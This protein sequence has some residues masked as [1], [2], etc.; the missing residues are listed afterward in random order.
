MSEIAE[1]ET[2]LASATYPGVKATLLSHLNKL[3]QADALAAAP[4][5]P[6]ESVESIP[7][8][9]QVFSPKVA[10]SS[11]PRPPLLSGATY[12]PIESFSWDQGAYN[13]PTVTIFVDLEGNWTYKLS[14]LLVN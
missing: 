14:C 7:T 2:L 10:S 5:A 11:Q 13:S 1:T 6:V 8:T 9:P 3:R 4:K 12:I